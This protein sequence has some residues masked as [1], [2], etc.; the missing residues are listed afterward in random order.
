M[1]IIEPFFIGASSGALS[2]MLLQPL[3]VVKTRLQLFDKL[4]T[5]NK[6]GL[7]IGFHRNNLQFKNH[8]LV[9]VKEILLTQGYTGLWKGLCPSL[10]RTVPGVGVYFTSLHWMTKEFCDSKP[11]VSESLFLAMLS[12][13][14]AGTAVMPF[15]LLKT[16]YESGIFSYHST[17]DA[18]LRVY[19]GEGIKGSYR[20]LVATMCRDVPYSGIYFVL[21]NS[22]KHFLTDDLS[23]SSSSTSLYLSCGLVSGFLSSL[24]TH[25]PDVVKT[26]VQTY[27]SICHNYTQAVRHIYKHSGMLGFFK[28][29]PP[30]LLK[31]T[32]T[33]A[34]SW[35]VFERVM[36]LLTE[37]R[38]HK[39]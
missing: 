37:L 6:A 13:T 15:A 22:L 35:T 36:H 3:D 24:L 2:T 27:P 17:V 10:L 26:Q 18:L 21:Y 12:R 31:K 34:L 1:S 33:S 28:G 19:R 20:G 23:M 8:S 16:R 39:L 14:I 4:N 38:Q 32:L 7:P 25:P 30:R 11:S 29:L 9:I 5:N